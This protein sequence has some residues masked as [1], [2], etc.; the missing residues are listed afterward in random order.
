MQTMIC[1]I[2]GSNALVKEHGRYVCRYCQSKY[3]L[4][5][6]RKLL[7]SDPPGEPEDGQKL[8]LLARRAMGPGAGSAAS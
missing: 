8:R 1:E 2:C 6:A 5:E 7:Q 4:E 3:S